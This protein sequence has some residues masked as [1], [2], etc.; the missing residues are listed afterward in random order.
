[1]SSLGTIIDLED[2]CGYELQA[3]KKN[4]QTFAQIYKQKTDKDEVTL[5]SAF[6]EDTDFSKMTDEDTD[7]SKMTDEQ[8]EEAAK[9]ESHQEERVISFQKALSAGIIYEAMPEDYISFIKRQRLLTIT[10]Y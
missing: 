1:M 2:L 4:A 5:P 10:N 7:F 9:Q 6:D 3:A 8:I